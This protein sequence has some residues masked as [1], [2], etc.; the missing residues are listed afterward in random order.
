MILTFSLQHF[1]GILERNEPI[2]SLPPETQSL[3]FSATSVWSFDNFQISKLSFHHSEFEA[4]SF[5]GELSSR[6]FL[7]GDRKV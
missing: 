7:Q 2:E 3:N 6:N 1:G 5:Y 4:I